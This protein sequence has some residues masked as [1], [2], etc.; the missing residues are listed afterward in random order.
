M[1]PIT[2][3]MWID[4]SSERVLTAR[5][6]AGDTW[7]ERAEGK[8]AEQAAAE[9]LEFVLEQVSEPKAMNELIYGALVQLLEIAGVPK[10]VASSTPNGEAA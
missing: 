1:T 9:I 6:I 10:I 4:P 5:Q 7:M 3:R 2:V 8:T